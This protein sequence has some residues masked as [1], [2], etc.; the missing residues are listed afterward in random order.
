MDVIISQDKTL[1][2]RGQIC[3]ALEEL[4]QAQQSLSHLPISDDRAVVCGGIDA[5]TA[6]LEGLLRDMRDTI[7][8][9]M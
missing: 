7:N 8:A 6:R 1:G 5:A 9:Q 2:W 4:D 3:R